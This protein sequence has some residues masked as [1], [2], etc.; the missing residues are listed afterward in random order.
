[1]WPNFWGCIKASEESSFYNH[2]YKIR[3]S[4][5]NSIEKKQKYKNGQPRQRNQRSLLRLQRLRRPLQ[6]LRPRLRLL[7]L[8]CYSNVSRFFHRAGR[9]PTQ[10]VCALFAGFSC[11]KTQIKKF[12]SF[13]F[14]VSFT[15]DLQSCD[16]DRR[17]VLT[18]CCYWIIAFSLFLVFESLES[19]EIPI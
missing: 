17:Q 19:V 13:V 1:M 14:I 5:L 6:P 16:D 7:R 11:S 12:K 10:N 2:L 9:A 18:N 8:G 4:R 15:C 3:I